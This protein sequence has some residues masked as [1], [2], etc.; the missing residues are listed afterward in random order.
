MDTILLGTLLTLYIIQFHQAPELKEKAK[1]LGLAQLE[2][3]GC[4]DIY[5][6]NWED[7][8]KFYKSPEYAEKM[9]RKSP[10]EPLLPFPPQQPWLIQFI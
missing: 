8:M 1:A 9:G 10:L 2:Y 7:W 3:D 4:S 6:K 5:V